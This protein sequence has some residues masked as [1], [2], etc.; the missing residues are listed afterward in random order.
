MKTSQVWQI[1]CC[2]QVRFRQASSSNSLRLIAG[3]KCKKW[4][5]GQPPDTTNGNRSSNSSSSSVLEVESWRSMLG[6]STPEQT[7]EQCGATGGNGH[8]ALC[9]MTT[10]TNWNW[11]QST[12][13]LCSSSSDTSP[14]VGTCWFVQ[15][16]VTSTIGAAK[17]QADIV[18]LNVITTGGAICSVEAVCMPWC[19]LSD[20]W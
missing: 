5:Y 14:C 1:L 19:L 6:N 8:V 13:S 11:Q 10:S 20:L 4:A 16:S 12:W 15:M 9:H 7:G 18:T 3:K 2:F 17:G